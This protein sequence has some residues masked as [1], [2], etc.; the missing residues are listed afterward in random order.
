MYRKKFPE[1]EKVEC[2]C[3]KQHRKNCG[4]RNDA[5]SSHSG[6]N[7]FMALEQAGKD[8][9]LLKA[10]LKCFLTMHKIDTHGW[11]V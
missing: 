10:R 9:N 2:K 8:P 4:C 1:V 5:F 3:A 11:T 6:S 7:I